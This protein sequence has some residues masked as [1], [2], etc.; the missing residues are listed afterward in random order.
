MN[1]TVTIE[2][3]EIEGKLLE[4]SRTDCTARC[5]LCVFNTDKTRWLKCLMTRDLNNELQLPY[6]V[7]GKVYLRLKEE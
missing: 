1:K 3:V 4:K 7:T 5:E 6:C 2:A